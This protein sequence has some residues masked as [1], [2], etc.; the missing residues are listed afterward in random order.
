VRPSASAPSRVMAA[1]AVAAAEMLE[2]GPTY[3]AQIV[4]NA[5]AFGAALEKR[6]IPVLAAHKG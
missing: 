2:F 5:Q 6:G 3:M 1:K 4:R